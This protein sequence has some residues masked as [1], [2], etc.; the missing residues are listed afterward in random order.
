MSPDIQ[1][2]VP[3]FEADFDPGPEK[4]DVIGTGLEYTRRQYKIES[5]IILATF[6]EA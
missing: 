3:I 2:S 5:V 6:S 1:L 4:S